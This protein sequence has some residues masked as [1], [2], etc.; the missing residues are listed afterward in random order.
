MKK[1]RLSQGKCALVDDVDFEWLNQWNWNASRA[2]KKFYAIRRHGIKEG[3]TGKLI[4]MHRVI[5]GDPKGKDVDHIDGN[6][7]NNQRSNLRVCTR[8]ENVRNRKKPKLNNEKYMGIQT[9]K[10]KRKTSYRAIIGH[11]KKVYHLGM[12]A[13]PEEAARAYDKKAVEFFGKF[14]KVN[15]PE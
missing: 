1:I 5:T 11:N 7:L 12:F 9:Y 3:G 4:T 8:A 10:G 6:G 13:S 15:F 2:G 14:A